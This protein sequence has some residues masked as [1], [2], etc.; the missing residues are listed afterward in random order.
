MAQSRMALSKEKARVIA[1]SGDVRARPSSFLPR[2]WR[3]VGEHDQ[4]PMN[5]HVVTG[6][7]AMVELELGLGARIRLGPESAVVIQS[8]GEA[9]PKKP[10]LRMT[11]GVMLVHV[12]RDL[13][14]GR[15]FTVETPTAVAGVR[16]TVFDVRVTSHQTSISVWEGVVEV[17]ARASRQGVPVFAGEEAVVTVSDRAQVRKEP[18]SIHELW[19]PHRDWLGT[20]EQASEE[21]V[22]SQPGAE[23]P[24]QRE[25]E[26][27]SEPE[28]PSQRRQEPPTDVESRPEPEPVPELDPPLEL[29]TEPELDPNPDSNPVPETEPTQ[30]PPTGSIHRPNHG[31]TPTPRS[32]GKGEGYPRRN[33]SRS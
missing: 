33:S 24:R 22:Q 6:P 13:M 17:R 26:R 20:L 10:T 32:S 5:T 30:P 1:I 28:P 27:T 21:Q 18:V 2:R 31:A 15:G 9:E 8:V 29:N 4:L 19:A 14:S 7:E 3:S 16:G 12:L 11:S 25:P 23:S